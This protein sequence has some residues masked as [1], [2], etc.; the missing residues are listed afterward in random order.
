[1]A[2][3]WNWESKFALGLVAAWAVLNVA[4]YACFRDLQHIWLWNFTSLAFLP[5]SVLVLTLVVDR[6]L[7]ARERAQR[8]EKLNMLLGVFFSQAGVHLLRVFAGCDPQLAGLQERF[9][10]VEVWNHSRHDVKR[11]LE[12]HAYAVALKPADVAELKTFLADKTECLLRIME[13]PSLLEHEQFTEL[14]RAVFHLAEELAYRGDVMALPGSD[15]AHLAGDAKRAYALLVR[16]WVA[17]MFYLK[18]AYPYLFSLSARMNP[19]DP[20]ASPVVRG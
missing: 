11:K 4:H 6:M 1:M 17:Y 18:S 7:A 9:C 3:W 16:E 12:S 5:L 15:M 10:G 13:N 14:L 19:L 2:K 8:L 20:D